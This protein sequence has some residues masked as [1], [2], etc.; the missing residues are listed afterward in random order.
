MGRARMDAT[1]KRMDAVLGTSF[2]DERG[3]TS[4]S[5]SI[6]ELKW[7]MEVSSNPS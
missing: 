5:I 6:A 1:A 3:E 2:L 7:L 4:D